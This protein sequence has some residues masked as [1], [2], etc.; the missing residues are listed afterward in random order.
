MQKGLGTENDRRR[1]GNQKSSWFNSSK[2]A[3][4]RTGSGEVS[5]IR[6]KICGITNLRDAVAAADA[7]ADAVGFVF[8]ES[9]RRVGVDAARKMSRKLPAFLHKVGVFYNA[10]PADVAMIARAAGLTWVQLHGDESKADARAIPFPSV[11]MFA[12]SAGN[13]VERVRRWGDPL[14]LLEAGKVGGSGKSFDWTIARKV[15]KV[16]RV[17]VA[18]GLRP[19]NVREAIRIAHPFAVDVA[20][21]VESHVGK[22]DA[23][24]VR[25][26]IEEARR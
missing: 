1:G 13:V 6:V 7:G 14:V 22:K 19:D 2:G 21:G 8:A 4:T 15:G 24:L 16:A 25:R 23:R 18:G 9:P 12:V 20:S 5:M 17:I 3:T 26:F 11:K 10:L